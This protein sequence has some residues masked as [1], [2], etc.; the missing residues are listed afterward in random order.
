MSDYPEG[1]YE[2]FTFRFRLDKETGNYS[3]YC[4]EWHCELAAG[5]HPGDRARGLANE[6]AGHNRMEMA[7]ET[8]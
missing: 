4:P 2:E 3:I 5:Q 6:I 7:H 1:L 8:H